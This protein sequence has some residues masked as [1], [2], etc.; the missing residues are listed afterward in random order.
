MR[1]VASKR[2]NALQRSHEEQTEA[3][4]V[5]RWERVDLRSIVDQ[6]AGGGEHTSGG[7]WQFS[8]VLSG[9]HQL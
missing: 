4:R 9:E 5:T 7:I 1:A 3:V 8:G 6:V 2:G